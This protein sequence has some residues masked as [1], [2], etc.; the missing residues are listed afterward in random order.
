MKQC[1]PM[2]QCYSTLPKQKETVLSGRAK[3][4]LHLDQ[5][6]ASQMVLY[7]DGE[8]TLIQAPLQ[9]KVRSTLM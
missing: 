6:Q 1:L 7:K 9:I 3:T 8:V 2:K 4:F 5:L